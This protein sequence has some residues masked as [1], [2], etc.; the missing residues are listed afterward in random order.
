[1]MSH[2]GRRTQ[3]AVVADTVNDRDQAA[4]LRRRYLVRFDEDMLR[5]RPL[6][7]TLG[8]D[9]VAVNFTGWWVYVSAT[10]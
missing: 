4:A 6:W 10:S 1:M 5:Q 2:A 3:P 8:P 9:I 7:I